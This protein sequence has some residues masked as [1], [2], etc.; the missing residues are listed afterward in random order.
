MSFQVDILGLK[1]FKEIITQTKLDKSL[2]FT[3]GSTARGV[4]SAL[5]SGI[6]QRYTVK[7]DLN[8]VLIGRRT[9]SDVNFG[10]NI[11]EK[12][13]QYEFKPLALTK[14]NVSEIKVSPVENYFFDRTKN[15]WVRKGWA[16]AATA[17]VLRHTG[18]K[19]VT[20]RRGYGGFLLKSNY[21]NIK[22]GVYERKQQATWRLFPNKDTKGI[23]AL[24][25]P[26]YGP[27][28][29]QMAEYIYNNDP[30]GDVDNIVNKLDTIIFNSIF[31]E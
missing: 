6:V 26:L 21:G 10:K 12:G 3:I 5:R 18:Y 25:T 27:S 23:R 14:F 20:G 31:N 30:Y 29:S 13:L 16:K 22:R 9:T 8:S 15:R 1:E 7:T 19:V 17:E 28:L 2:A 4:H 24:I 11:V